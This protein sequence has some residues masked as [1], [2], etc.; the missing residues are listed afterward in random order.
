MR[1]ALSSFAHVRAKLRTA[2]LLAL[3]TRI[4]GI[5]LIVHMD[6]FRTTAAPSG[7][8][9]QRLLHAEE[10]TLDIRGETG[11]KLTLSDL[12]DGGVF[13]RASVRE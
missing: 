6:A 12:L 7:N 1:R 4:P 3:K 5:P 2:A 8:Q 13:S 11:F 9:W 10:N